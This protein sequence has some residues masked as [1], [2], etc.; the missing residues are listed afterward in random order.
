[1]IRFYVQTG[2]SVL[3]LMQHTYTLT[4]ILSEKV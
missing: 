2:V 1:M 3:M 4:D